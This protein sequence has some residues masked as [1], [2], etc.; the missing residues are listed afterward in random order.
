MILHPSLG[1]HEGIRIAGFYRSL[2][3][4][5]VQ[6]LLSFNFSHFEPAF[7]HGFEPCTSLP[8][9]QENDAQNLEPVRVQPG[10]RLIC[11]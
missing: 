4:G 8:R 2:R 9:N 5:A 6:A 1:I 3:S 10:T 11:A 7:Q